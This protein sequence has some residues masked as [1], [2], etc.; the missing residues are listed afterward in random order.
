MAAKCEGAVSEEAT[1]TWLCQVGQE[2]ALIS[3]LP[4]ALPDPFILFGF[5]LVSG[6]RGS[7]LRGEA[8]AGAEDHVLVQPSKRS[9][10]AA[11]AERNGVIS[12]GGP[13][14]AFAGWRGRG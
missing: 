13:E 1:S 6:Q 2:E 11:P 10:T 7:E 4:T 12:P 9:G 3:Q 14:E 5:G 8:L